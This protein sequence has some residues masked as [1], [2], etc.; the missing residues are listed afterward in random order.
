MT[1]PDR[2]ELREAVRE[3]ARLTPAEKETTL[4]FGKDE[5][6]VH[7][8]TAERGLTRRLISHAH[9]ENVRLVVDD[10]DGRPARRVGE[11]DGE[12]IVGVN[13][14]LPIGALLVK[15][16]P[17]KSNQHAPVVASKVLAEEP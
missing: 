17:R 15:R 10:G 2:E 6:V 14:E 1:G 13:L 11:W 16:E 4:R 7:V 5:D 3:D 9:A 8:F 12:P